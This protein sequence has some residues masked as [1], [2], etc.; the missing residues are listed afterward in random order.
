LR[1]TAGASADLR[2]FDQNGTAV[3]LGFMQVKLQ[4]VSINWIEVVPEKSPDE[5]KASGRD[6]MNCAEQ[7]DG[8]MGDFTIN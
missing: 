3:S 7:R 2:A 1:G 6:F 8:R 5:P 4:V